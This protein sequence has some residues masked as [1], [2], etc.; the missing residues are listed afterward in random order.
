MTL[1]AFLIILAAC[2]AATSLL[3]EGVKKFLDEIKVKYA[4]NVIVLIIALLVG[5]SV[6]AIYYIA[7]DIPCT[8]LNLIYLLLMGIANWLGAMLG[9]DRVRQT[10][11]QI[12][13]KK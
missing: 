5:G 2:S 13:A 1:T 8:L 10:I 7:L 9:Y 6:T 12:A 3:T 4:S 11:T